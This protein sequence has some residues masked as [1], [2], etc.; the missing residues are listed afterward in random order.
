MRVAVVLLAFQS[1][2][3]P[4]GAADPLPSWNDHQAKA[5]ILAFV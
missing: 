2:C 3:A 5:S 1:A 4:A